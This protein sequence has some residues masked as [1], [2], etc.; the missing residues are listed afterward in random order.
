MTLILLLILGFTTWQ[1]LNAP[2]VMVKYQFSTEAIRFRRQWIRLISPGFLHA[3]WNH[4][5]GN[6]ITLY[7]FG[8]VLEMRGPQFLLGI[9][10]GSIIGGHL[11]CMLLHKHGD[12]RAVGASG[13]ALGLLFTA[14]LLEPNIS[15]MFLPGWLYGLIFLFYTLSSLRGGSGVS[16]EAHLG[17]M[18]SGILLTLLRYPYLYRQQ[19]LLISALLLLSGGGIWYF[20]ANPGRVPGFLKFQLHGKVN[21]FK[22]TQSKRN[23]QQVDDL[24]DKVSKEGI[25][26]LS[27]RERKI[28]QDASRKRGSR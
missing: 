19:P 27:N 6:A 1:G 17:G 26:S 7:F 8:S 21:E 22:Q 15:I 18:L 20:H 4:F 28:L 10:F 24:L 13:G 16:H 5:F 9:F 11:L 25:Q 2:G 23:S 3:N 14:I 12:Y